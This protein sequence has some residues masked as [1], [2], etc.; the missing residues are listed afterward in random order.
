MTDSILGP[1]FTLT[2]SIEA[3]LGAIGQQDWL[4]SHM[5]LMPKHQAWIRRDVRTSRA[6]ATTAIEGE[7]VSHE[8]VRRLARRG[9]SL[10]A[11]DAERA[12]LNA[13][14]AYE[15]VDYVADRHDVPI[16]EFVIG[17]LNRN[18]MRGAADILTPGVYRKGQNEVRGYMPPNAGDVPVLMRAFS[19]WL[20]QDNDVHSILKACL[21]HIHL[22]AIHPFWDGNGR[23]G[24]ALM[25]LLLQRSSPASG[26]V[27]SIEATA[28]A[29][30]DE[31]FTAIEAT[32]GRR[33]DADYDATPWLEYAMKLVSVSATA[34]TDR[35]TAWHR[36]MEDIHAAG[37]EAGLLERHVDGLAFAMQTG[38][39]TRGDYIEITGV[40]PVTASRDLGYLVA[41]GL[42]QARG[43][44]RSRAYVFV[45]PGSGARPEDR[46]PDEQGRLPIDPGG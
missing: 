18:F 40:S 38:R 36:M 4:I 15:F 26:R 37:E 3:A 20:V 11:D 12:N 5:L 28:H 44:T 35:L 7:G 14:Q 34:V 29:M 27:L 46:V 31:Y 6:H 45:G 39:I 25:T 10:P 8:T 43:R 17:E 32:L 42:L 13:L 24:R 33:F 22:V 2:P 41:L 23:S 30:R 1:C 9:G 19:N 21:A 16:D